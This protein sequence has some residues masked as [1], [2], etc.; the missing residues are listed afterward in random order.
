M[1]SEEI[2]STAIPISK[3]RRK[4]LR[5]EMKRTSMTG[6][7]FMAV[8]PDA[9]EGLT[10]AH[11]SRWASGIMK[12]GLA[13]HLDYVLHRL[14]GMP[15]NAGQLSSDGTL[16][17]KNGRRYGPRNMWIALTEEMTHLLRFELLRTGV[18]AETLLARSGEIPDGL[19]ARII[20]NWHYARVRTAYGPY[21]QF[22][23][24]ALAKM[25]SVE[26]PL[27]VPRRKPHG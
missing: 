13:E 9:P 15:D 17:P 3:A 27:A 5:D 2:A 10:T 4:Q 16:L 22:V 25:P 19:T 23:T 7:R 1:K 20:M 12:Q 21:W 8:S 24:D 18:D 26:N 11:I 14:E 6:I